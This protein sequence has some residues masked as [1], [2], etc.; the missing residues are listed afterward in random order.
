[1]EI[2]HPTGVVTLVFTDIE[3]S[4]ALWEQHRDAFRPLLEA[5]QRFVARPCRGVRRA[6][7]SA[8]GRRFFPLAFE[9]ASDAVSFALDAQRA[10]QNQRLANRRAERAIF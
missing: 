5:A 7:N 10:I 3:G 1:M 2:L 6:G 8:S 9:R 4:S